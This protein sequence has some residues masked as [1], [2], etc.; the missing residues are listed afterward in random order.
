MELV[1]RLT[2][3]ISHEQGWSKDVMDRTVQRGMEGK[4]ELVCKQIRTSNG[5]GSTVHCDYRAGNQRRFNIPDGG[6]GGL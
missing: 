4:V 6:Q 5:K 1:D 3:G 2:P